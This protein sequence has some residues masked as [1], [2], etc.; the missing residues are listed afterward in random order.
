MAIMNKSA[1]GRFDSIRHN[2]DRSEGM[3]LGQVPQA[4]KPGA[5]VDH[6]RGCFVL[7]AICDHLLP[8]SKLVGIGTNITRHGAKRAPI[9][10][11]AP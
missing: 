4:G 3:L 10:E 1:R 7:A 9:C 11:P 5:A 2:F 8:F 6:L